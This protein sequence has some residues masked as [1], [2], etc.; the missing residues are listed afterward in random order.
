MTL[1][2]FARFRLFL[3]EIT[4]NRKFNIYPGILLLGLKGQG[5][6]RGNTKKSWNGER[7][8]EL[9]PWSMNDLFKGEFSMALKR[10]L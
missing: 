7:L 5:L 10:M 9:L 2:F 1:N 3:F 6:S 8:K 4:I